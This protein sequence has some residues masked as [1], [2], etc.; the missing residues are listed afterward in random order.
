MHLTICMNPVLK[1]RA[2]ANT[3]LPESL[4]QSLPCPTPKEAFSQTLDLH[5]HPECS[6]PPYPPPFPLFPQKSH[7]RSSKAKLCIDTQDLRQHFIPGVLSE[8]ELGNKLY[9]HTLTHE[10]AAKVGNAR[11]YD[12]VSRDLVQ[13]WCFPFVPDTNLLPLQGQHGQPSYRYHRDNVYRSAPHGLPWYNLAHHLMIASS[14]RKLS[15]H[16]VYCM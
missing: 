14:S 13:R 3:H 10:Y 6:P 11:A 2:S 7:R 9:L 4:H 12:A 15:Y 5:L 16:T 1:R 8:E